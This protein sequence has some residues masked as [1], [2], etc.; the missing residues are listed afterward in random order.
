MRSQQVM[1]EISGLNAQLSQGCAQTVQALVDLAHGNGKGKA[2]TV[3]FAKCG[4]RHHRQV[5]F[6]QKISSQIQRPL[7][8]FPLKRATKI[9]GEIGEEVDL[10]EQEKA[11][12]ILQLPSEQLRELLL[13]AGV[14]GETLEQLSDEELKEM[15]ANI[16]SEQSGVAPIATS[17]QE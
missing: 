15:I 7:D 2:Q 10:S 17:T 11:E 16:L 3:V 4:T 12:L 8:G 5:S 14:P 9:G 6:V 1:D 13:E